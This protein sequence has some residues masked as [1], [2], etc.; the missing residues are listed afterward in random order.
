MIDR[1][2]LSRFLD[3]AV[4]AGDRDASALAS[5]EQTAAVLRKASFASGDAIL[6][7]STHGL[8]TI[9]A[10]FAILD[11]D[12]VPV[13]HGPG[14]RDRLLSAASALQCRAVATISGTGLR[15]RIDLRHVPARN[16]DQPPY[17]PGEVVLLTSGTSGIATGCVHDI[18]SLLTNGQRHL[19]SLDIGT[20][21][22]TLVSLPLYFS[23]ALVAQ[24]LAALQSEGS[25]VLAP[26]PFTPTN[27]NADLSRYEIDSAAL[28]PWLVHD[29]LSSTWQSPSSLQTLSV[30]GA[31]LPP[32]EVR[33]LRDRCTTTSLAITYGLT[34]AGPRVSTLVTDN[35]DDAR[36]A[37]V[38]RPIEG[39]EVVSPTV[40][41]EVR[42]LIVCTDTAAK[43]R[44]GAVRRSEHR[45]QSGIVR[46]G[47]IFS[48][49]ADG[50]L[51]FH[52]RH[53]DI[54]VHRGNKLNLRSVRQ[55][56]E[57]S[58]LVVY[59]R[60]RPT[61]EGYALHLFA[62]PT[63]DASD[64]EISRSALRRLALRE[65]PTQITISRAERPHK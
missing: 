54:V 62:Q 25:I 46:T 35:I 61:V 57:E 36:L 1:N 53:R 29:L 20:G 14:R 63:A 33:R 17:R 55:L 4:D 9:G 21:Y 58:P 51:F 7:A 22:R 37:S 13:P 52:E 59:S 23:F 32:D 44:A 30:G 41:G 5:F 38:G 12:L 6:L 42:E 28:T 45:E 34:E 47:D 49:D 40:P 3:T 48:T 27:F 56:V 16:H 18:D 60:T 10:F 43:R 65:R 2:R 15:P 19:R 31:Q 64:S 39:V 8:G 50:Y 11:A 26:P 24:V